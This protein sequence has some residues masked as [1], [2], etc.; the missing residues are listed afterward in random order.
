MS[1]IRL[2]QVSKIYNNDG[3][4]AV[5]V[6][7]ISLEFN[8][9]EFVA[10]TGESGSGKSTLLNVISMM[11]TYEEG[12]LFINDKSTVEFTKADFAS[13][14][15]NYVSF[16]F[17]EYNLVDSFTVL[18]NVMLP[19]L[20]RGYKRSE[21]KKIALEAIHKVGLDHV[22]RHKAT[23][24]SG[25]E[26]QRTVIA[27]AL[28]SDTP[29]IACDEPTGNLDSETAVQIINLLSEVAHDKLILFVTHDYESIAHVA[30]RHITL[31]DSHLESDVLIKRT[32]KIETPQEG[33]RRRTRFENILGIGFKDVL[34]TPKKSTLSL[35]ISLLISL[36]SIAILTGAFSLIEPATKEITEVHNSYAEANHS[37]N[38]AAV[39]GTGREDLSIP[40]AYTAHDEVFVDRGNIISSQYSTTISAS[41]FNFPAKEINIVH[42]GYQLL[43]ID[44][45]RE[46]TADDECALG[47]S[48]KVYNSYVSKS[49]AYDY[50]RR[51][52]LASNYVTALPIGISG[53]QGVTYHPT[54]VYIIDNDDAFDYSLILP[55]QAMKDL[56]NKIVNCYSTN[57]QLVNNFKEP[58]L[59]EAKY[60]INNTSV[61]YHSSYDN[62]IREGLDVSAIYLP[63]SHQGFD[64]TIK[65]RNA[66]VI[67]PSSDIKYVDNLPGVI[68][69]QAAFYKYY[70]EQYQMASFYTRSYKEA[71]NIAGTFLSK[72]FVSY[73]ASDPQSS[74]T[75]IAEHGYENLLLTIGYA[76]IFLAS[77][78][79]ITFL[80]SLILGVIYN[81]QKKDYAIYASLSYSRGEIRAINLIEISIFFIITSLFSYFL[82]YFLGNGLY[83]YFGNM[84]MSPTTLE[85][86][87]SFYE[88]F[89][90][91]LQTLNGYIQNPLFIVVFFVFNALFALLVSNWVMSKFEHKTLASNLKKGGELL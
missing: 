89:A 36:S 69:H 40:D 65:L 20:S 61:N 42:E 43:D 21:A 12:E 3:A 86:D 46:P 55:I 85:A 84:A 38:R 10:I 6:Q 1:T 68:I 7:N 80:G 34:N 14:R 35:L 8:L 44:D 17:Q 71:G 48:S 87:R 67:V 15:A 82:L 30:T 81:S 28:V 79:L 76:A 57:R 51:N 22:I 91:T 23:H 29:I 37:K 13:F 90:K 39:F 78:I 11:D 9:G 59:S 70:S 19:L 75:T 62:Y 52:F 56:R 73:R 33:K 47:I 74:S 25:G 88:N 41:G 26:K 64:L 4:S 31:A 53:G 45:S 66:E 27:R 32:D 83:T 58:Y 54:A 49:Y 24:L 16:I 5:G 60:Y 50:F 72:G 77:A 2:E 18:D 63:T